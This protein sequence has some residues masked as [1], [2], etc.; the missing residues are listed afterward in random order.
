M[1]EQSKKTIL[2]DKEEIFE[3]PIKFVKFPYTH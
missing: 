1:I 3:I 2:I